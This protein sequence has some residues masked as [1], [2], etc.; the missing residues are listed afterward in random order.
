MLIA[1]AP[2]WQPGAFDIALRMAVTEADLLEKSGVAPWDREPGEPVG[3]PPNSMSGDWDV[4]ASAAAQGG[5]M[6]QR[7]PY[8]ELALMSNAAR[9]AQ[10]SQAVAERAR[11][12]SELYEQAVSDLVDAHAKLTRSP[13][14]LAVRFRFDDPLDV[15]LLEVIEN[16]PGGD[17][18]PLFMTEFAPNERF[19]ILGKLHLTMANPRQLEHAVA[20]AQARQAA[21]EKP[22]EKSS[23]ATVESVANDGRVVYQAPS[24]KSL[25]TLARAAKEALGLE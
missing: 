24:P 10:Q 20:K 6:S 2:R 16:F 5:T 22:T 8:R 1:V 15:H 9:K 18:D 7:A 4:P 11:R 25:A 12:I 14:A 21:A 3:T 19:R 17:E 13:L 23:R